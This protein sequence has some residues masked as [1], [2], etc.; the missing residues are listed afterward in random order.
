MHA[1]LTLTLAQAHSSD[2]RRLAATPTGAAVK[3]RRLPSLRLRGRSFEG[4]SMRPALR[5][6]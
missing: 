5:R 4:T 1:Q 6:A 2:L 3:R